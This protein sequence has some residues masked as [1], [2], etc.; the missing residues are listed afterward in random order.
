MVYYNNPSRGRP[1]II[2]PGNGDVEVGSGP[3]TAGRIIKEGF[4]LGI[5]G[6]RGI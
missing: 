6:G 1:S 4:V 5:K 2:H 3:A